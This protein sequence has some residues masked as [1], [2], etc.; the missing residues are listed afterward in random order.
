MNLHA[1]SGLEVLKFEKSPW[2]FLV[3]APFLGLLRWNSGPHLFVSFL[4]RVQRGGSLLD[5]L[6]CA[7]FF[8]L[9]SPFYE[10]G[11]YRG[12]FY[13]SPGVLTF[14]FVLILVLTDARSNF[15]F[16]FFLA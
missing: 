6:P 1:R 4:R 16:G 14:V 8:F 9:F 11:P 3:L 2:W 15:T 12:L 7:P 10:N 5:R 13:R